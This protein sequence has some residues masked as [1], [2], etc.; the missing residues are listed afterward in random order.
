MRNQ[1]GITI[2][3]LLATIT[4]LSVVGLLVWGIFIQGT[5]FSGQAMTK[6]ELTQ[7]INIVTSNF[8]NIHQNADKYSIYLHTC[9]IKIEYKEDM[10][11]G[12]VKFNNANI[13]YKVENIKNSVQDEIALNEG[14]EVHLNPR[15]NEHHSINFDL[16]IEENGNPDNNVKIKVN[17][18]RLEE[19]RGS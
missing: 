11:R 5:K 7:E 10:D 12:E 1:R 8:K 19:K 4:I 18:F 9:S 14:N 6:N 13:C 2:V 3:E 15:S 17:L 16:I